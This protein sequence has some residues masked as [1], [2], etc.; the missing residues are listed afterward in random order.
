MPLETI[1]VSALLPATPAKVY[2]AWL[3]G[4]LHPCIAIRKPFCHSWKG[5][6]CAHQRL[7]PQMHVTGGRLY[8][9]VSLQVPIVPLKSFDAI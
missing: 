3:D 8:A 6:V 1:Q 4:A 2:A 7:A 5:R 9:A